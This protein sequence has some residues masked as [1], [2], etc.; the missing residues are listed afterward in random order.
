MRKTLLYAAAGLLLATGAAV[1]ASAA[2][3][4]PECKITAT[5][6]SRTA[7]GYVAGVLP[8]TAGT[9]TSKYPVSAVATCSVVVDGVTAWSQSA[10]GTG[11]AVVAGQASFPYSTTGF[12]LCTTVDYTSNSADTDHWCTTH[13]WGD[14]PEDEIEYLN[15]LFARYV[16]PELCPLL[17]AQSPGTYP[18][19]ITPEGDVYVAGVF[20]WDC[21]PYAP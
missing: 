2:E 14:H 1:P 12:K 3:D 4:R 5:S 20:L 17:A 15:E 18:V 16:D 11:V 19:D 9:D 7:T 13:W 10:A 6:G 21:P 8:L